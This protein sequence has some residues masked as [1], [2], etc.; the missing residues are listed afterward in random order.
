MGIIYKKDEW[1]IN[2]NGYNLYPRHIEC[3]YATCL[4]KEFK[5]FY[6]RICNLV[7][8]KEFMNRLYFF[9]KLKEY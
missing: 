4:K 3:N 8:P 1:A 7:C 6:C 5:G 9:R 2:N